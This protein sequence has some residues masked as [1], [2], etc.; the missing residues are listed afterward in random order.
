MESAPLMR[1]AGQLWMERI[2]PC[3]LAPLVLMT[4]PIVHNDVLKAANNMPSGSA[5]IYRHFGDENREEIAKK[6][7][8]NTFAKQQQFLIGNDPT[9]AMEVGA[10]GVHFTRDAAV[11]A[12]TLWKRRI[13]QWIVSMAG[14]KGDYLG[15]TG[16]VSILNALF[17]SSIFESQSASSGEPIGVEK[18]KKLSAELPAPIIALGGVNRKNGINLKGAGVVGMAGRF[19]RDSF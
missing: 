2:K 11:E 10:D 6:L 18:L 12:P 9:L 4:D 3:A 15:Y 5:I 8:V 19:T 7:R 17:I 14:I 13:P 1:A 16:D